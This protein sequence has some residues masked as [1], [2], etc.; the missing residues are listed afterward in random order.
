MK[1][2]SV[3]FLVASVFTAYSQEYPKD[4][5]R[6]PLDIP[7]VLAGNFGELRTNHFHT[8]LDLTTQGVEGKKIYSIAEGYISRI[9]ISPWGYGKV[10]YV[11]HPNGMTSVYAHCSEFSPKVDSAYRE[12]QKRAKV[13]LLDYYPDA[14]LIP[15][16]K[17]E[18]IAL[19]GNTGLSSGP[20]VHFE[21]RETKTEKPINP[22]LFGFD[23]KDDSKPVLKGI[24][25]YRLEHDSAAGYCDKSHALTGADGKYA[26]QSGGHISVAGTASDRFGI[27]IHAV[28]YLT[29]SPGICGVYRI[30]L[31]VDEKLVFEQQT[32][33]L[34]FN[35]NRYMNAHTD[36]LVY[37]EHKQSYHRS[38]LL[39]N[40]QLDIYPVKEG[41]GLFNLGEGIAHAVR[42]EVYDVHGNKSTLSFT[43]KRIN[44]API[45]SPVA[46]VMLNPNTE[47]MIDKDDYQLFLP[48]GTVYHH[49]PYKADVLATPGAAKSKLIRVMDESVPCQQYFTIKIKST[50][51][52]RLQDKALIASYRNGY[53][54]ATT[55]GIWQ[56]GWVSADV[57]GF[58]DYAVRVDTVPPVVTPVNI[59][60]GK[61]MSTNTE[62]AFIAQDDLSGI[63]QF[64]LLIND[65]WYPMHFEPKKN[66]YFV[67]FREINLPKGTHKLVFEAKDKVGNTSKWEGS[68][69]R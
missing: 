42:Y 15:V 57:R 50:I 52:E 54:T 58:G 64:D 39:A 61:N 16:K 26:L 5:F 51:P 69:V 49:M 60:N 36:Y 66:K 20:H 44:A 30:K 1:N 3:L 9:N 65:E 25:V 6:S 40:N 14:G 43:L 48:P 17:G 31:F 32:E 19:S 18:V 33:K 13:S 37:K 23:I 41:R 45:N 35:T 59:T 38:F 62:I 67:L 47:N 46:P 55:K 2:L 34:D 29:G 4:Y 56:N 21:I 27:A 12:G 63:K 11:D 24:R 53:V 10:V 8:G 28:D 22:L 7:L 68:F